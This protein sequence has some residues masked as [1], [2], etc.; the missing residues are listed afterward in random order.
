MKN[1]MISIFRICLVHIVALIIAIISIGVGYSAWT[2]LTTNQWTAGQTIS[3]SLM[4]GI[5][6]NLNDLN[7][8]VGNISSVPA[9]FIGSFNLSTCPTGW[10]AA[11][12]TNGT[13]DLRWEFVR[14]LDSGRWI[15]SGRTLGT[16]Q[17][18]EFK[19]HSHTYSSMQNEYGGWSAQVIDNYSFSWYTGWNTRT[20]WLTGWA[21][22]R[23]RNVA[24][25]YCQK[26]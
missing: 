1:F 24:L 3:Q 13:P 2:A 21:E 8:R 17:G 7:T 12:G 4:Q 16:W 9:G 5:I 22:T 19:N 20:S 14:G 10:T 25:L 18:D 15:D 6:D 23:P 11:N 26:Q